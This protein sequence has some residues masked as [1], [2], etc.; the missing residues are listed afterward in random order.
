M[1]RGSQD[2]DRAAAERL[3]DGAVD[4]PHA[5]ALARLLAR[6]AAPAQESELVGEEAAVAAFRAA[7]SAS[8]AAAPGAAA[9]RGAVRR[10]AGRRRPRLAGAFTAKIAAAVLATV[11]GGG[12]AVAAGTLP[13]RPAGEGT[14]SSRTPSPSPDA[15]TS[16]PLRTGGAASPSQRTTA[17]SKLVEQCRDYRGLDGD[18][19]A[20]ALRSQRFQD[21]AKAAGGD[22][23]VSRYC[24]RLLQPTPQESTRTAAPRSSTGRT[25]PGNSPRGRGNN[26]GNGHKGNGNNGSGNGNG[27]GEKPLRAPDPTFGGKPDDAP[28][29][30]PADRL[31]DPHRPGQDLGKPRPATGPDSAEPGEEVAVPP[32]P[33][34]H[35]RHGGVS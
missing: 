16:V 7:S 34:S 3:L 11:V 1:N 2:F 5:D 13:L 31:P 32:K 18:D 6:A 25:L 28:R 29:P 10:R 22:A 8:G 20:K 9:R 14:S 21:L 15:S 24:S 4:G 27:G 12:V 19:K 35:P 23:Q 33:P 26:N 30:R 17:D